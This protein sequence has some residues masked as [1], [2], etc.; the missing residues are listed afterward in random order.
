LA[1]AE[2]G[3]CG[4]LPLPDGGEADQAAGQPT[5]AG[6]AVQV[7]FL[8]ATMISPTGKT[9]LHFPTFVFTKYSK[10]CKIERNLG[11]LFFIFKHSPKL[12]SS[13]SQ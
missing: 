3:R 12:W 2:L 9:S 13:V 11:S 5:P 8:K 10:F 1:L 6:E 4:P 7:G